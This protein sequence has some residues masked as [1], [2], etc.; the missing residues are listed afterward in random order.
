MHSTSGSQW[1]DALLITL[2]QPHIVHEVKIIIPIDQNDIRCWLN[3][4]AGSCSFKAIFKHLQL[5]RQGPSLPWAMVWK[6]RVL[7][8]HQMF[9][10]RVLLNKLPTRVRLSKWDAS[11]QPCCPICKEGVETIDHLMVT[12]SFPRSISG[13]IPSSIKKP[14]GSISNWFWY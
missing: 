7:P 3:Q 5:R 4:P 11:I 9:A 14:S 10:W 13:H 2:W 8:K 1:N 6:M 12:C